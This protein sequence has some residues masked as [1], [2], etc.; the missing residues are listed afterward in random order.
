MAQLADGRKSIFKKADSHPG[1]VG[2]GD[3]LISVSYGL[4]RE[5]APFGMLRR[6][7]R[8]Q[9]LHAGD[10]QLLLQINQQSCPFL[11]HPTAAHNKQYVP[12][13]VIL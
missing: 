9:R 11:C 1:S 2:K 6:E 10:R 12:G 3:C 5:L 8:M 13:D 7:R 4:G